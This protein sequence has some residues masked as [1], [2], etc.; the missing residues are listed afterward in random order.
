MPAPQVRQRCD[1]AKERLRDRSYGSLSPFSPSDFAPTVFT[2]M[3]NDLPSN[4]HIS[5]HPCVRAKLS[6]LRSQSTS[7]ADTQRLV[8]EIATIVGC[9]ALGNG[10]LSIVESGAVSQ[11]SLHSAAGQ[12][13]TFFPGTMNP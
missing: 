3:S 11:T 4:V 6:Q 12:R 8:H 2:N 5:A 1:K 9:E 13:L 7:S 10:A